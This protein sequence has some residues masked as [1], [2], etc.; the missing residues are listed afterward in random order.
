MLYGWRF[1]L[2]AMVV[3]GSALGG[4]ELKVAAFQADATPDMGEPNIWVQP[5]TS[6]MDPLL[7][8]GIVLE[9]GRSRYVILA[10]DWCGIGGST[11]LMLRQRIAKAAGTGIQRV[12]LQVVHQHTAPYVEG[13]G[14]DWMAARGLKPLR[15]SGAY[16]EKLAGNLERAVAGAVAGLQP[17]DSIG[18]GRAAVE[19]VGSAR[20][21]WKGGKIL[22][23]YSSTAK[24]P[25]LAAEPEGDIDRE[26]RTV[27]FAQGTKPLVRMHYYA[28]H[29]QTFCCDGRVTSD[30]VGAARA[31][32]EREE[33][34][35]QVYFTGCGGDVTVGKYNTG[36]D[37]ERAALAERMQAGMRAS[38]AATQYEKVSRMMW[39]YADLHL[40]A[41][42]A[43]A[44]GTVER[45][46]Q[47]VYRDAIT[48]AFAKRKRGLPASS[49]RVGRLVI[50]H[51]PG[52]PLLEF[53][54]YA[55][56]IG[57]GSFV[58]V[59][60]YGEI[61]PGYLCPDEAFRQGGYEPSA[62]NGTPGAEARVKEVIRKLIGQ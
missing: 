59:A 26:I 62:S 50:V 53:Q 19:R 40:P 60:G 49:L 57:E 28:S 45:T 2:L 29:P 37:S 27:T 46:D 13:D 3:A 48:E 5:V 39:T 24:A 14:Y 34:V 20:R 36:L 54:R 9:D 25:E 30:F 43:P 4:A 8:K 33:G 21:I 16:L 7:A 52:E 51:L 11:H 23:R 55:Q 31:R 38:I 44:P 42:P 12:A 6:V 18:M 1:V 10:V 61:S 35:A 15:M 56:R 22:V 17:F 41:K 47:L 32:M 58:A